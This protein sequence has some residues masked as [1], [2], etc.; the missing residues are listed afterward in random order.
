MSAHLRFSDAIYYRMVHTHLFLYNREHRDAQASPSEA[1][2][3]DA[4]DLGWRFGRSHNTAIAQTVRQG[5][6]IVGGGVKA[7][8]CRI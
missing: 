6:K 2:A 4:V 8:R 5:L 3:I 1:F 7:K